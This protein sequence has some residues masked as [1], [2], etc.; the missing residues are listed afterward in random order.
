[1]FIKLPLPKFVFN[2]DSLCK[3]RINFCILSLR[4]TFWVSKDDILIRNK[5]K[6]LE[7]CR[8][9]AADERSVRGVVNK[10]PD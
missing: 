1:M 9:K 8:V 4:I 6:E 10:F 2:P 5:K 7:T 3:S